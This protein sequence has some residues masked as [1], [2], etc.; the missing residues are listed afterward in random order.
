MSTVIYIYLFCRDYQQTLCVFP[1]DPPRRPACSRLKNNMFFRRKP[2]PSGRGLPLLES[3]RNPQ[4][5]PRHRVV[6]SLGDA[7]LAPE[8]WKAVAAVVADQL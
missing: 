7:P 5:Q 4:G 2:S 8:D 3:Y 1:V 6:L